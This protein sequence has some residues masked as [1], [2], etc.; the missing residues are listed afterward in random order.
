M[1]VDMISVTGI[2]IIEASSI[3]WNEFSNFKNISYRVP[4]GRQPPDVSDL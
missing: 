3:N 1:Q 2:L 4:A